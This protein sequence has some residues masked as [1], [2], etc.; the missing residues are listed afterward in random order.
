MLDFWGYGLSK[1]STVV[2]FRQAR[3]VLS[4][5]GPGMKKPEEKTHGLVDGSEVQREK[6][7][8]LVVYPIIY[9]VLYM[10]GGCLGVLNHQQ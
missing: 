5:P 1:H 2:C 9:K 4:P 3:F 10:S 6:Q 7:W 8:R